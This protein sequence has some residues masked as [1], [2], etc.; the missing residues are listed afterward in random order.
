MKGK[1][2]QFIIQPLY[3]GVSRLPLLGG[4]VKRWKVSRDFAVE[5][6]VLAGRHRSD[7]PHPSI[8]FFTVYKA[9][10]SFIGGFMKKIVNEAGMTPVDLDGYFFEM[11]KGRQ[12]EGS[13]RVMKR[14]SYRPSGYFYGP[15]RSFN[16]GIG[17]LDDYKILLVLRD[18]RDVIVSSYY[19]M[20]S[21]VF[22]QSIEKK[23]IEQRRRRRKKKLEQTV[24][25]FIINKMNS[26]T[27]LTDQYYEYHKELMAGKNV[28]FLKYED[29]VANFD[30]WL[31]RLLVFLD[32]GTSRQL[33][34]EIKSGASFNVSKEDIYKH[35]RQVKPGEH[36][37]KLKPETV[38]F[39]DSRV[40]EVLE[41]FGYAV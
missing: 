41:L 6:R 4:W 30:D 23:E 5:R 10:S 11:G 31:N 19:S 20:Y 7:S 35:K 40:K 21:H 22:P 36:K 12:W 25:E 24:D 9:A 18:P 13:G 14:V 28:L 33:I 17:N 29:M 2:K 1:L 15:F 32:L 3:G 8:L 26:T 16:R 37:R 38:D 27:R 34:D 39:L